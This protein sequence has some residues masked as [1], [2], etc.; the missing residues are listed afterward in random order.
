MVVRN[1]GL[2]SEISDS[3]KE[4]CV[5]TVKVFLLHWEPTGDSVKE[6]VQASKC[7][8]ITWYIDHKFIKICIFQARIHTD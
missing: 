3:E 6:A 1:G 8:T 4:N 2:C 7:Y 5:F